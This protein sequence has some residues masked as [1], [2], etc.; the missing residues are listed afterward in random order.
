MS[1]LAWV[2]LDTAIPRNHKM[3]A[4]TDM[5]DGHRA[6]FVYLCSLAYAGEQGTD[7][8]IPRPAL[9]MIHGRPVEASK[10]CD[11]GLW[12]ARDGGWQINDWADYQ[13]TNDETKQRTDRA[14]IAAA[15]RWGRTASNA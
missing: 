10:L 4:L 1:G 13:Q 6:G 2:R 9:P 3:L 7:G 5:K 12:L 14:R 15:A 8:F 11:V